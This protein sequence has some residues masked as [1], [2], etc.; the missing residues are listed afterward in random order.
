LAS[1]QLAEAGRFV[2]KTREE[3]LASL[4]IKLAEARAAI[5]EKKKIKPIKAITTPTIAAAFQLLP[6]Y[7]D[8]SDATHIPTSAE[9]SAATFTD[10]TF[11]IDDTAI[12]AHKVVMIHCLS[13]MSYHFSTLINFAFT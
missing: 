3:A 12:H 8:A 10:V 9:R 13:V 1:F 5:D 6:V 7:G 11:I 4:E 2:E